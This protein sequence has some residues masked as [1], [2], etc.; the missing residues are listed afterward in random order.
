DS[1]SSTDVDTNASSHGSDFDDTFVTNPNK[2]D[3]LDTTVLTSTQAKAKVST[4]LSDSALED[5]A[6][7]LSR[8][9]LRPVSHSDLSGVQVDPHT[10]TRPELK[11]VSTEALHDSTELQI[12]KG[13][14][15]DSLFD[16]SSSTDVD[17]DEPVDRHTFVRP[18][19]RHVSTEALHDSTELQIPKGLN[20][21]SLFDSS[22]ST[23]V[24]TNA[25]SHGSDFDDTFVTNPNK[26][27]A[28]D[29]TVL[30]STQTKAK[31]STSL[32]DSVLEDDANELSRVQLR[33][34]SHSDLSG[35]QVD[36]HT[37]TRPELR[38]VSTEALHDSTELQI[39]KGLNF[40][41][42]FDSS[43]STDV[44]TDEP[45]DRHIFDRPEL[46]HV[47]TEALHDSTEL[48]IPKGLNFDSL[49]DS[50]SSADVDTDESSHGSDFSETFMTNPV[51]VHGLLLALE[52]MNAEKESASTSS[53]LQSPIEEDMPLLPNV[54]R[55]SQDLHT[56]ELSYIKEQLA[57]EKSSY[58]DGIHAI[59]Q[60]LMQFDNVKSEM[61]AYLKLQV[62]GLDTKSAEYQNVEKLIAL[63][64]KIDTS[65]VLYHLNA[66]IK[67]VNTN[68]ANA[69][70]L[71][72]QQVMAEAVEK[73]NAY[74]EQV[75]L[76]ASSNKVQFSEENNPLISLQT[77]FEKASA[78]IESGIKQAE[79]YK[80]LIGEKLRVVEKLR[81]ED[82]IKKIF[83]G[84]ALS[85]ED[86]LSSKP[87]SSALE[88][89]ENQFQ[90]KSNTFVE[91]QAQQSKA[92][93]K[94]GMAHDTYLA[95]TQA[96]ADKLEIAL[97]YKKPDTWGDWVMVV[98]QHPAVLAHSILSKNEP[99]DAHKQEIQ[100]L[101]E[102][103]QKAQQQFDYAKQDFNAQISSIAKEF[104]VQDNSKTVIDWLTMK[105]EHPDP[106]AQQQK[107]IG[108]LQDLDHKAKIA[109]LWKDVVD[110]A[111][112]ALKAIDTYLEQIDA[113]KLA[114]SALVDAYGE[115]KMAENH[116][117][118]VKQQEAEL[119]DQLERQ[120]AS[121]DHPSLGSSKI[122]K[123]MDTS[124]SHMT[125]DKTESLIRGFTFD[126]LFESS[127]DDTVQD[128]VRDPL[129]GLT[130]DSLFARAETSTESDNNSAPTID[131]SV[132]FSGNVYTPPTDDPLLLSNSSDIF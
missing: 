59:N 125:N 18:E 77:W 51:N 24:D 63:W 29:T 111:D 46:K 61:I 90:I 69:I 76:D 62:S 31:V 121:E 47:S 107:C 91:K 68:G 11:H 12:P 49:F 104:H 131:F 96:V 36:P 74:I 54:A 56:H 19:L 100:L 52:K 21:D 50:S 70:Y 6:N 128:D 72:L 79:Q 82:V 4:S 103:M 64:E 32:S 120:F 75:M 44:D 20:F 99:L 116:L 17:T 109:N 23:D 124:S 9:Q 40:D 41:S 8:I 39:P 97:P 114:N 60:K 71:D 129:A 112:I 93:I 126:S 123:D 1:S 67:E 73:T 105:A 118:A 5:D 106:L 83:Y 22:S 2:D 13:L 66:P 45:V 7:E 108:Y 89:A 26:D 117:E 98:L 34:V 28:L 42:L 78:V 95:Q 81:V 35:V 94:V 3:A 53:A 119:A 48:Q 122:A 16:S 10:F 101:K 88:S 30:T 27:D 130:F 57:G 127:D 38:H 55:S 132:L 87:K 80:T 33:P 14:N 115:Y 92:E 25:S 110:Q 15:F 65:I 86:V 43:S 58:K 37:F 113:L 85:T 84:P 102:S